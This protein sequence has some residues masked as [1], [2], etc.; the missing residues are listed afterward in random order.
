M[1]VW[2]SIQFIKKYTQLI[3]CDKVQANYANKCHKQPELRKPQP[4]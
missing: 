2:S 4:Y 1:E 3:N